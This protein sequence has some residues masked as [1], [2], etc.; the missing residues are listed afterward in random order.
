MGR[1][2]QFFFKYPRVVFDQ[3]HFALTLSRSLTLMLVAAAVI[4]LGALITYRGAWSEERPRDRVVL[5]ALRVALVGLLLFC[6]ARPI[7]IL[8]AAVPQQNFL[9]IL[10][11]DSRSMTIA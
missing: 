11:D 8:K 6:L 7:L 1:L 3:G 9:G 4:A 2:F 10:L 5:V